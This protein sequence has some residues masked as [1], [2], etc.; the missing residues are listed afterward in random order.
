MTEHHRETGRGGS[1]SAQERRSAVATR[2]HQPQRGLSRWGHHL[3]ML[4]CCLPMLVVVGALVATGAAGSGAIVYAL[5]CTAMMAAMM[6]FMPG[7]KH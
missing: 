5:V 1:E 4:V 6:F 2:E 3:M 7:H